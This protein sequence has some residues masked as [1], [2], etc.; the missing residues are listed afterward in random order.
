MITKV[1]EIRVVL[2]CS[3][4]W[5]FF[6]KGFLNKTC[7]TSAS[8]LIESSM[9]LTLRLYLPQ[10]SNPS[11]SSPGDRSNQPCRKRKF[12]TYAKQLWLY[13]VLCIFRC[14]NEIQKAIPFHHSD[15]CHFKQENTFRDDNSCPWP[16]LAKRE[17]YHLKEENSARNLCNAMNS[18][19]TNDFSDVVYGSD[20]TNY[21]PNMRKHHSRLWLAR[22]HLR[23]KFTTWLSWLSLGCTGNS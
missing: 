15:F 12:R 18:N 10:K 6:F 17:H 8:S 21:F 9:S 3:F 22:T 11:F 23:T 20:W 13:L 7:P 5:R 4:V 2:L 19:W 14:D 1:T 16:Q